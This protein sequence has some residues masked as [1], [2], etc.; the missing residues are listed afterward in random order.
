MRKSVNCNTFLSLY[1]DVN[2]FQ[3]NESSVIISFY[4][5]K[6][7]VFSLSSDS[8][9]GSF[10]I[11]V[12]VFIF[13]SA[14]SSLPQGPFSWL[15]RAGAPLQLRWGASLWGGFSRGG[16]WALGREGSL[17]VAHGLS[18]CG[19]RALERTFRRGA[20]QA[21]LPQGVWD[22]PRS[23][24]EPIF[25]Y[26]DRRVLYHWASREAFCIFVWLLVGAEIEFFSGFNV[27]ELMESAQIF[28][29]TA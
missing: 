18:S 25:S 6:I 23:G 11:Y 20:T 24:L 4:Q 19:P 8:L 26:V 29:L 14:G 5:G 28:T 16:A 2:G 12:R 10:D 3:F 21:S 17:E 1:L 9:T 22:P 27:L 7:F 15:W 13:G